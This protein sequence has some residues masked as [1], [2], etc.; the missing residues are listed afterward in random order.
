MRDADFAT[1]ILAAGAGSRLGGHGK[2]LLRVNGISLVAKALAT[3]LEAGTRPVLVLGHRAHEVRQHL[4][5]ESSKEFR[6]ATCVVSEW[7]GGLSVSFRVGVRSAADSGASAIAVLLVDQPGISPEA[8]RT[9]INA[10]VAGRITRGMIG[11]RASHPVSL[12]TSD[13]VTASLQAIGDEGARR[14]LQAN[15]HRV[16]DIDITRFTR[17]TDLDTPEDLDRYRRIQALEKN[18]H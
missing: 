7:M 15:H 5:A 18:S 2:A 4:N 1:V 9:V 12:S 8:L 16:D 17:F 11:S 6:E 14:F 3:A 13:A 10:R